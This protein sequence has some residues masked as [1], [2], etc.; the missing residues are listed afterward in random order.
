[1]YSNAQTK[2]ARRCRLRMHMHKQFVRRLMPAGLTEQQRTKL[3]P[4]RAIQSETNCQRPQ[5]QKI[6]VVLSGK[7]RGI[8]SPVFIKAGSAGVF[9]FWPIS[10]DNAALAPACPSDVTV[11]RP[12]KAEFTKPQSWIREW[13]VR[14]MEYFGQDYLAK[15][16]WIF[17]V[18]PDDYMASWR[19]GLRIRES[20]SPLPWRQVWIVTGAATPDSPKW[21]GSLNQGFN[22]LLFLLR[23]FRLWYAS[24]AS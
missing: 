23:A 8:K 3:V 24:A 9:H 18:R 16:N 17:W 20:V 1:M 13:Q 6:L 12:A 21:Y 7:H 4:D 2:N 11:F 10:P 22:R 19:A 5:F 14:P 15:T